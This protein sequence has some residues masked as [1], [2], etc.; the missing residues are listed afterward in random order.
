[1]VCG[2]LET[3]EKPMQKHQAVCIVIAFAIELLSKI[4]NSTNKEVSL[5]LWSVESMHSR[6][7]AQNP[8]MTMLFVQMYNGGRQ[9]NK[10]MQQVYIIC[11]FY[12]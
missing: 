4:W 9:T 7:A 1:M 10:A 2:Y 3:K 11:W 6:V 12:K 8:L 5:A